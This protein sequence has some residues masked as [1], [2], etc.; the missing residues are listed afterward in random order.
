MKYVIKKEIT[1]QSKR[2]VERN[3]VSFHNKF[4][5]VFVAFVHLRRSGSVDYGVS[6]DVGRWRVCSNRRCSWQFIRD[7]YIIT[8]N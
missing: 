7:L 5:I 4:A 8:A 6:F 1:N 2:I 3:I